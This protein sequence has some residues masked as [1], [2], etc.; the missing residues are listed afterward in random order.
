MRGRAPPLVSTLD[1]RGELQSGRGLHVTVT[2]VCTQSDGLVHIQLVCMKEEKC[3]PNTIKKKT[4]KTNIEKFEGI[5]Y[6]S[7]SNMRSK[8]NCFTSPLFMENP[9]G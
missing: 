4:T 5:I 8:L 6:C 1:V 2:H 7:I 9:D 3:Y